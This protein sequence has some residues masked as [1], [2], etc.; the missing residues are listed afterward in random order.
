MVLQ[1]IRIVL[2]MALV[3]ASAALATPPGRLPLALRGIRRIMLKDRGL[4]ADSSAPAR[5]SPLRRVFAFL[6][7]LVAV[8]LAVL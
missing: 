5:A 6:L 8:I 4:P 2:V 3:I 1:I 7:L